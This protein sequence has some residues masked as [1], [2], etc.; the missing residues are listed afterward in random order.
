MLDVVIN[1]C[2][3]RLW[4]GDRFCLATTK[5]GNFLGQIIWNYWL[6]LIILLLYSNIFNLYVLILVIYFELIWLNI[7]PKNMPF[8]F[9][10]ICH[11]NKLVCCSVAYNLCLIMDLKPK[12]ILIKNDANN[13]ILYLSYFHIMLTKNGN[14]LKFISLFC[15]LFV[16]M[17]IYIL[18]QNR[19]IFN[20]S[21]GITGYFA[22]GISWMSRSEY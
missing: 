10:C 3:T 17:A 12:S 15:V 8:N 2:R 20:Q 4:P 16:F 21:Y 11:I 14:V 6:I 13:V 1:N 9:I 22:H 5:N 7:D 19:Y 18:L